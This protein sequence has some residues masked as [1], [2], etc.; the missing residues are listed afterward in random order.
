MKR[1]KQ[2]IAQVEQ[3]L[4]FKLG[5]ASD[6]GRYLHSSRGGKADQKAD[7]HNRGTAMRTLRLH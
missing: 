5:S 3:G 6:R 2:S 4:T 7:Q 1:R